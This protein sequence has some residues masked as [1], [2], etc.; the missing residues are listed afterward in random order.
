MYA[1]QISRNPYVGLLST[2]MCEGG[3]EEGGALA[4]RGTEFVT[5][6]FIN[7]YDIKPDARKHY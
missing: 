2:A 5:R 7:M 4:P 6:L 1:L 3:K